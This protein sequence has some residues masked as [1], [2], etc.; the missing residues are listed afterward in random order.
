[1]ARHKQF[2][3]LRDWFAGTCCSPRVPSLR[4]RKLILAKQIESAARADISYRR[5][6]TG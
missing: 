6:S 4:R 2:P 5:I 3:T 1:M